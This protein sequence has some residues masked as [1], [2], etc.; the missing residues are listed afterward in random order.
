M[1][2]VSINPSMGTACMGT[3]MEDNP[4]AASTHRSTVRSVSLYAASCSNFT[5]DILLLQLLLQSFGKPRSLI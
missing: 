2:S 1:A 5:R 3:R 4:P